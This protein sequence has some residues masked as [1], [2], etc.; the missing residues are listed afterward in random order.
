MVAV[1]HISQFYVLDGLA[2]KESASSAGNK[3]N[4]GSVPGGKIRWRRKWQ[5][6]PVFLPE[7]LWTEEL[8]GLQSMGMQRQTRLGTK[9]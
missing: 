4:T 1:F 9:Q 7:K 8:G 5:P 3:G 2:G 6:T